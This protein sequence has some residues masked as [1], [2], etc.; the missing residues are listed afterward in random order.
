MDMQT[1]VCEAKKALSR[2]K[3]HQF[4]QL[5]FYLPKFP[6]KTLLAHSSQEPHWTLSVEFKV[7]YIRVI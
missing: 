7:Q 6:E 4:F 3:K 5:R 1:I 2:P